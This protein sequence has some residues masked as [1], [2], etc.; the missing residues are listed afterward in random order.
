MYNR[1]YASFAFRIAGCDEYKYN[2]GEQDKEGAR[3]IRGKW[4]W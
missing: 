3:K 2:T 1:L 4:L